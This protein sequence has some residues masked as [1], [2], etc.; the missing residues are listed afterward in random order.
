MTD[1]ELDR[2][3]LDTFRGDAGE[4]WDD[5]YKEAIRGTYAFAA[6]RVAIAWEALLDTVE[7]EGGIVGACV[8]L[9]RSAWRAYIRFLERVT[10]W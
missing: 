2:I 6:R 4:W 9:W 10:R 3:T 7:D 8:H 5:R 1:A